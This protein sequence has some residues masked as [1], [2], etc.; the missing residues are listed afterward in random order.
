MVAAP[1][2]AHTSTNQGFAWTPE[3]KEAFQALKKRFSSAQ[4]CRCPILTGSLW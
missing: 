3:A 2:T 1:L 4:S